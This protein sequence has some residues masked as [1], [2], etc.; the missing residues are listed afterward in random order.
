M[1]RSPDATIYASLLFRGGAPPAPEPDA[2][3]LVLHL[4]CTVRRVTELLRTASARLALERAG[5]TAAEL[6][7]LCELLSEAQRASESQAACTAALL[8]EILRA[9]QGGVVA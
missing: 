4:T 1:S 7:E 5:W 8:R 6:A 3:E 9:R 2:T